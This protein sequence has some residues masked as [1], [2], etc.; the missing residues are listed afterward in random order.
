MDT[1]QSITQRRWTPTNHS[2]NESPRPDGEKNNAHHQHYREPTTTEGHFA[3]QWCWRCQTRHPGRCKLPQSD[4]GGSDAREQR[5]QPKTKKHFEKHGR[6]LETTLTFE[7][8]P[9][10]PE[11][12]KSPTS[13]SSPPLST[14]S[15]SPTYTHT[16]F[17]PSLSPL[18]PTHPHQ[19]TPHHTQT[20]TP[21][22]PP[23]EPFALKSDRVSCFLFANSSS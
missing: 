17:S 6:K 5:Q 8:G 15:P 1:T 14:P 23:P 4:A 21:P 11:R 10:G 22:P 2:G 12:T 18:L 16:S 20:H 19:T 9:K 7:I 13:P 3:T